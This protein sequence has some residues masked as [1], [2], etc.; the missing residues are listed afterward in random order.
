MNLVK[1][2][3]WI[4]KINIWEFIIKVVEVEPHK[5]F[6]ESIWWKWKT[7]KILLLGTVR[8]DCLLL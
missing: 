8:D 2:T 4:N 6:M 5:N 7:A 1:E 3:Q